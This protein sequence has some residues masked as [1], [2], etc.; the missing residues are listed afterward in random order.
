MDRITTMRS[1]GIVEVDDE[2]LRLDG[3]CIEVLAQM[4]VG[5]L[6]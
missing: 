1:A 4:I 5:N 6:G 2:K 3:V